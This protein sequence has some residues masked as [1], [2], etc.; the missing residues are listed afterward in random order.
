M[1]PLLMVIVASRFEV[2]VFS[3]TFTVTDASLD[4]DD[5]LTVHQDLLLDTVHDTF[6]DM[7]NTSLPADE[8]KDNS[9]GVTSR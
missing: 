1:L 8:V 6:D 5:L 3:V 7:S 9:V 2:V 4:P